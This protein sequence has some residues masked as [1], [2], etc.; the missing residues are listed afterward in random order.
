[1]EPFRLAIRVPSPLP[2]EPP[3]VEE[4][5]YKEYK[6]I[7][8][9]VYFDFNSSFLNYIEKERLNKKLLE[10]KGKTVDVIGYTDVA[11]TKKFN[12]QLSLKRAKRVAYILIANEIKVREVIGK[13]EH[14][15]ISP[16]KHCLN[17]R[18]EIK[19]ARKGGIK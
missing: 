4:I 6:D 13:G 2:V 10:L 18:V 12:Y 11:G 19:E 15:N 7:L 9:T 1:M 5:K 17:R 16:D 14:Y 8:F 3:L